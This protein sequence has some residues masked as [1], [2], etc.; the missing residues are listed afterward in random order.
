ML[1]HQLE[2]QIRQNAVPRLLDA[3]EQ[4]WDA[5][6]RLRQIEDERVQMFWYSQVPGSG[7]PERLMVAAC[8]A[9]ANRGYQVS[10]AEALLLDGI[11][12]LDTGDLPRLHRITARIFHELQCAPCNHQSPYW[13]Y[14]Q[15]N[16]WEEY[17]QLVSLPEPVAVDVGSPRFAAR[18][19][20]GWLGQI[21]GGALGTALEGYT[22]RQL[23]AR[24]GEV[25]GYVRPPNTLNDDIAYELAFLK[26]YQERGRAV[27]SEDIAEQWV[28]LIPFGWSAEHIALQNLKFGI[29]PPQSGSFCNPFSEWIGAQMRGAVLGLL[30]PGDAAEAARLAWL[31][32]VVS[33][34]GNGVLGEVFNA[35]LTSLAFVEKDTRA[36]LPAATALLPAGTEYHHVIQEAL[37]ACRRAACWKDAWYTLEEGLERYNWVHA[38]PNAAAEVVALWYGN[39]DFDRTMSIVAGCGQDVDCNAAQVGTVV[40]VIQ[41]PEGISTAWSGPL[42]DT[43]QTYVR[44]ME[45]MAIS[46]LARWTVE[47]ARQNCTQ[48]KP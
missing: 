19:E 7:A 14:A 48:E 45:T 18:V 12:C 44:G 11:H 16:N 46:E 9:M 42:E 30:T 27:R 34:T 15:V 17:V 32:G 38:Y 23:E 40:G 47:L 29:Y 33:H 1:A 6:G 21:A 39:G 24:F 10:R 3:G 4:T 43:L 28:A 22:A 25:R 36:L 8:Q 13:K 41:G 35:V 26:A 2:R 5:I 37:Q 31:D 20:A